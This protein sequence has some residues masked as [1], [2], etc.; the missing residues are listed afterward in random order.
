AIKLAIV[1][2]ASMAVAGLFSLMVTWWS[3]PLDR[4]NPNQFSTL[5]AERGVVAIGYA[6]FAFAL[7][8][9]TGLLRASLRPS[10]DRLF[11]LRQ[12]GGIRVERA[13]CCYGLHGPCPNVL[14]R[15]SRRRHVPAL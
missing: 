9:T 15:S 12:A 1:G 6:A 3:S 14:S 5:F 8:V 2:L 13:F 7:G 11:D 4:V 10:K